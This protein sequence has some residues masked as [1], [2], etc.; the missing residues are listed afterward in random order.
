M[1]SRPSPAIIV[2]ILALVAAVAGTA[3]A[4]PAGTSKLTRSKV[5]T[6][7]DKEIQ[8]LASGLSVASANTTNSAN[9]ANTATT[10]Q[11]L[12][13]L[14]VRVADF[15]VSDGANNGTT[16]SCLPGEQAISG[17]VLSDPLSSDGRVTTSRPTLGPGGSPP[18]LPS[19][20]PGE[21]GTFDGWRAFV[22]NEA[23]GA[24]QL[25]SRVYVVCA[26]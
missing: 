21:G 2:A 17:G 5:R 19:G 26:V 14:V 23:G 22:T 20:P 3:V 9:T 25:S 15:M 4:G 11:K 1:S 24:P 13:N 12:G 6:I 7:A 16:A 8:K 10:A 18:G